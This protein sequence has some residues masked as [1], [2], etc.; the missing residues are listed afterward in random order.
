MCIDPILR[1]ALPIGKICARLASARLL[2]SFLGTRVYLAGSTRFSDTLARLLR[3]FKPFV[4]MRLPG[5]NLW[6]VK[7][8][9]EGGQRA[10]YSVF[11]PEQL[12]CGW[13]PGHSRQRR[14]RVRR[15]AT[16]PGCVA[17]Q[18]IPMASAL[19]NAY[20]SVLKFV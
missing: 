15:E 4:L 8:C 1:S 5:H 10:T 9:L 19:H 16:E 14:A 20:T 18:P 7:R 11:P 6:A 2:R 3:I 17:C 12:L 13:L